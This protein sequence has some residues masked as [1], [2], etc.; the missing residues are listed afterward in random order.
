MSCP[1]KFHKNRNNQDEI[2]N[3][4]ENYNY[5]ENQPKNEAEIVL[6]P[7][8]NYVYN[9]AVYKPAT[10]LSYEQ[11]EKENKIWPGVL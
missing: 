8:E 4:R 2:P 10:H 6:P 11:E 3:I 5:R 1:C 7:I 9:Y